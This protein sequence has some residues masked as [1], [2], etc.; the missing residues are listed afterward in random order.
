[1]AA[2]LIITI[3]T[4]TERNTMIASQVRELGIAILTVVTSTG[5]MDGILHVRYDL[6]H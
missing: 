4:L 3:R 1:M 5:Q 6:N 2:T